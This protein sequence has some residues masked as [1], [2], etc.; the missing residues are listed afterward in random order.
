[1]NTPMKTI[2]LIGGTS[3]PSTIEYY[4]LLNHMT[5]TAL[6]DSHSARLIL[7]SIDYQPI[8]SRYRDHW[9]EIPALL[10]AEFQSALA[11]RPDCLILCN[12]TLHKA[13]DQIAAELNISIPF[14]HALDLTAQSMHKQGHKR[15]LLLATQASMEDPYFSGK[16]EQYGLEVVTPDLAD[17][18]HIQDIQTRLATGNPVTSV[19]QAYFKQLLDQYRDK[20]DSVV[21][22]CTELPL[23]VNQSMTALT[24]V[25]TIHVQCEAALQFALTSANF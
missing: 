18:H 9:H 14:F 21:L 1:M 20:V 4:R 13:Y 8:K 7:Y 15:L 24:I 6:G 10:K 23:A 11:L 5:A 19:D 25:N 17:R 3:W 16:F 2:G 12:N 22:A